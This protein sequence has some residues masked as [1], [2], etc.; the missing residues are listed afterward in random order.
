VN[1]AVIDTK[2][3]IVY[4]PFAPQTLW[5]YERFVELD[6]NFF[7]L[8]QEVAAMPYLYPALEA[9]L[10]LRLAIKPITDGVYAGCYKPS[11][12][13]LISILTNP[14]YHYSCTY[15]EVACPKDL[16]EKNCFVNQSEGT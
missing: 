5:L 15:L 4:P 11:R 8:C 12:G 14:A 9:G 3:Y 2:K 1:I 7:H 16:S 6:F 13:G 10:K